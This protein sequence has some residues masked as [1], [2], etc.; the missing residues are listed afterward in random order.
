MVEL[1]KLEL[2]GWKNSEQSWILRSGVAWSSIKH[3]QLGFRSSVATIYHD[4]SAHHRCVTLDFSQAPRPP[5][6]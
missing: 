5:S 1:L 3:A 6:R 4:L 2:F